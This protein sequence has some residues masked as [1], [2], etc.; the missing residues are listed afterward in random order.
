M[1]GMFIH[2]RRH[3]HEQA[4]TH[5]LHPAFG[6]ASTLRPREGNTRKSTSHASQSW[7]RSGCSLTHRNLPRSTLTISWSSSRRGSIDQAR[8]HQMNPL[9]HT[10]VREAQVDPHYST[11]GSEEA[12]R[13]IPKLV[14]E[15][16]VGSPL[17]LN[18]LYVVPDS[19]APFMMIRTVRAKVDVILTISRA[20]CVRCIL[21][22]VVILYKPAV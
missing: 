8:R 10:K 6:P 15:S 16:N 20:Y 22:L 2:L 11:I 3:Q 7:L 14:S 21:K 19:I 13:A 9:P 5:G 12:L 1:L 17:G 18:G 4:A